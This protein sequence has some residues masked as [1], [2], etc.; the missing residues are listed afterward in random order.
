MEVILVEYLTVKEAQNV[1]TL[2]QDKN[3]KTR[4]E[5]FGPSLGDGGGMYSTILIDD[6]DKT[7]AFELLKSFN[8]K[9]KRE[10]K[11]ELSPTFCPSCDA[12]GENIELLDLNFFNK[13]A[14][15]WSRQAK[16][17]ACGHKWLYKRKTQADF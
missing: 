7:L 11:V 16:C 15:G 10:S 6:K 5:H 8:E 12:S 14:Y 2:L 4:I 13:L 9:M 17:K 3:I 1:V